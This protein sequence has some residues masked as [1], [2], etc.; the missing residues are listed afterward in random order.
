MKQIRT[1]GTPKDSRRT[2][3]NTLYICLPATFIE[4][5]STKQTPTCTYELER[6]TSDIS[7]KWVVHYCLLATAQLGPNSYPFLEGLIH[8]NATVIARKAVGNVFEKGR[9]TCLQ[10][11]YRRRLGICRTY[12]NQDSRAE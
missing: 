10:A 6:P 3:C 4:K 11:L 2:S 1:A 9:L 5:A 12:G 8:R 7:T